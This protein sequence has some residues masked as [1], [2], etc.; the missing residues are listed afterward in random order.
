EPHGH[1]AQ[2]YADVGELASS[3]SAYLAAG[4]EAGEPGVVVAAP[5][6]LSV[7]MAGLAAAGWDEARI[8]SAGLLATADAGETLAFIMDGGDTPSA[9]KFEAAVGGLLDRFPGKHVRAFGEMVDLLSR[10]SKVDAAIALE[11]LWNDLGRRRD[12]ALLCGYS[13][14]VFDRE[15]QAGVLPH[16]CRTHSHMLPALDPARLTRAV[17][18]ALEEVLGAPEAG[19]VY[20][21]VGQQL[22]SERIPMGQV[23]LMWVSANMPALAERV[24]ASARARYEALPAVSG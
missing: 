21:L 16:V 8:Q 20:V 3:V 23:L 10:E 15:A 1:A 11:E 14:N 6:H 22:R 19:K 7:F 17:D 24:L 4:F 5:E 13:L 18:S 2:V 9:A 12:F